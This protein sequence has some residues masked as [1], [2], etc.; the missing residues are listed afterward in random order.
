[1]GKIIKG[2]FGQAAQ[3]NKIKRSSLCQHGHHQWVIDT[4]K[5]FDVKQG[6]L[7]TTRRCSKCGKTRNSA[8]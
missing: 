1:M 4:N 8:D 6:K 5:Q 2:K 7:I 3:L